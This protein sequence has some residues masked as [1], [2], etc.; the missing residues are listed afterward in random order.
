MVL[1]VLARF[2][3]AESQEFDSKPFSVAAD[4]NVACVA[5]HS[6]HHWS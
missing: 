1:R 3:Y 2:T 5:E 4:K 6:R